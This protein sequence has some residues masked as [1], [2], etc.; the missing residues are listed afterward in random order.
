MTRI[1]QNPLW[2]V[3]VG[4]VIFASV[5]CIQYVFGYPP[6]PLCLEQRIP[7]G[8][9]I[10]IMLM[11]YITQKYTM[12]IIGNVG[13]LSAI[14]VMAFGTSLAV[15]HAGIQYGLW[16]MAM[17]CAGN[18]PLT[19]DS[20]QLL[21]KIPHINFV[22]CTGKAPIILGLTLSAWNAIISAIMTVCIGYMGRIHMWKN[23]TR[24]S[25]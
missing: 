2:Y 19:Q 12:P 5:L 8:A 24:H 7:W 1:I 9:M 22:D 3:G 25:S 10:I 14:L 15:K 21:Q 6:C 16:D 18:V 20:T 13:T 23:R 11:V 4:L 17:P